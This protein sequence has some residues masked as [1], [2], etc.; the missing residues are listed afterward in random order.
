M[1]ERNG[2]FG[3]STG[4]GKPKPPPTRAAPYQNERHRI[5]DI[6]EFKDE[7]GIDRLG[8]PKELRNNFPEY[9]F[10]W[11]T[12]KVY[13]QPMPQHRARFERNG[14]VSVL[15]EE[16]EGAF[17]GRF[18]PEDMNGE[19]EVDGLVLMA[20]PMEFSRK[21]RAIERKLAVNKV[22][23]KERQIRGGDI[24][25]VSFDTQHQSALNF[26]HVK[27]HQETIAVPGDPSE[28]GGDD[29]D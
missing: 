18:M 7:D 19:I 26:N 15:N 8:I 29:G 4:G 17:K 10:Q 2:R 3:D 23:I 27:R 16:F 9:D 28:G 20:R 14:W 24:P 6:S 1:V 11:V 25:G 5:R 22:E 12:H 13:G 21:A